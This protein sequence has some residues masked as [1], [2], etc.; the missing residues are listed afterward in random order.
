MEFI[1]NSNYRQIVFVI[2]FFSNALD[3]LCLCRNLNLIL[4]EFG[5]QIDILRTV[6][7]KI[8]N[9]IHLNVSILVNVFFFLQVN[10]KTGEVDIRRTLCNNKGKEYFGQRCTLDSR[11][12]CQIYGANAVLNI[13]LIDY[14]QINKLYSFLHLPQSLQVSNLRCVNDDYIIFQD[15]FRLH[16]NI[17]IKEKLSLG[18]NKTLI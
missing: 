8:W 14:I 15:K 2:R 12:G 10:E 5:N 18:H 11:I 13:L 9:K 16:I 7:M 6:D 4:C 1:K 3:Y 17:N